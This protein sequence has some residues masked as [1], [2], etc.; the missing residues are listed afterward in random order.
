MLNA[1]YHH[2][3]EPSNHSKHHRSNR[4]SPALFMHNGT[5]QQLNNNHNY[6]QTPIP[7][8]VPLLSS[9]QCS[10]YF[11]SRVDLN[12]YTLETLK[13]TVDSVVSGPR[14]KG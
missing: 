8:P 12:N 1:M 10:A 7:T 13:Q 5:H 14:S 4:S 9:I 3:M 6:H 11:I 2:S